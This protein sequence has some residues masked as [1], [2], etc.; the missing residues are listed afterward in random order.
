MGERD[1]HGLVQESETLPV[2][3]PAPRPSLPADRPP[4]RDRPGI[5]GQLWDMKAKEAR[6]VLACYPWR[7]VALD[8]SE[9]ILEGAA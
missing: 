7:W 2:S 9:P 6:V 1:A 8:L 4:D 5:P 3:L